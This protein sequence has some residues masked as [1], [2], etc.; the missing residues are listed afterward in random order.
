M[1]YCTESFRPSTPNPSHQNKQMYPPRWK[2]QPGSL[3]ATLFRT[4][5]Q[6][7]DPVLRHVF[8]EA[9]RTQRQAYLALSPSFVP[10]PFALPSHWRPRCQCQLHHHQQHGLSIRRRWINDRKCRPRLRWNQAILN[11]MDTGQLF[12]QFKRIFVGC[13]HGFTSTVNDPLWALYRLQNGHVLGMD[14][15]PPPSRRRD[16]PIHSSFKSA[17]S[18]ETKLCVALSVLTS[19][20]HRSLSGSAFNNRLVQWPRWALS[21]HPSN[22]VSHHSYAARRPV[23]QNWTVHQTPLR[24]E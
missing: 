21:R 1:S 18:F 9:Y 7:G 8:L 16:M 2:P 15:R 12:C 11:P 22:S 20:F 10:K 14:N 6:R 3:C 23:P 17:D 24:C 5:G 13:N 19:H 4:R